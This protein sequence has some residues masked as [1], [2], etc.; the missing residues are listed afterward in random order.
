MNKSRNTL[1]NLLWDTDARRIPKGI[2]RE[3]STRIP[4]PPLKN[5]R[6][7]PQPIHAEV[8]R[9]VTMKFKDMMSIIESFNDF[10]REIFPFNIDSKDIYV[11]DANIKI[12]INLDRV[13]KIRF[14]QMSIDAEGVIDIYI[15]NRGEWRSI[16][17]LRFDAEV[18]NL[19]VEELLQWQL[20]A[21]EKV[22]KLKEKDP[23]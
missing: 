12:S 18:P 3:P 17:G 6:G 23:A 22:N 16:P 5:Q 4:I 19:I 21:T 7:A 14:L 8:G 13:S 1:F 2:G 9:K 15:L 10:I 20:K 11:N